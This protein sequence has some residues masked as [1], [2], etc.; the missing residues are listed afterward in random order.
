MVGNQMNDWLIRVFAGF[1][2]ICWSSFQTQ[3]VLAA[4]PSGLHKVVT[5][6]QGAVAV[7]Y[8][9]M[10]AFHPDL[11]TRMASQQRWTAAMK[12]VLDHGVWVISSKAGEL[13]A[14]PNLYIYISQDDGR[15]ID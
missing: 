2:L 11:R 8:A 13:A 4:P 6:E 14:S 7:G 1:F 10:F 5:D 15:L 12:A 3:G 9:L